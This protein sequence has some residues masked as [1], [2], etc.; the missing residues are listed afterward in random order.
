MILFH[1]GVNE[2]TVEA[3]PVFKSNGRLKS[4]KKAMKRVKSSGSRLVPVS[5]GVNWKVI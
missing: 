5:I 1:T 3:P 4:V 2:A